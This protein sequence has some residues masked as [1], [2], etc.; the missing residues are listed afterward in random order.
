MTDRQIAQRFSVHATLEE[1]KLGTLL[2]TRDEERG[3][4]ALLLLLAATTQ[5]D[6]ATLQAIV[7]DQQPGPHLLATY[8]C[9]RTDEGAWLATDAS[10]LGAEATTLETVLKR[11]DRLDVQ[12]ILRLAVALARAADALGANGKRHLDISPNRVWLETGALTTGAPLLF[13]VGWW[14]LL[15][16]YQ[17]GASADEFYGN[18]EYLAAEVCKGHPASDTADVYGA[19]TTVWA[20][21]AGK[22]PFPSN[23]PLMA[24]K[25]QAVEKPLRLDLVK[26]AL[27]G[28][29]DLQAIL[30]EALD[31]DPAKRPAPT[32]W[33]TAVETLAS[34]KAPEVLQQ[35]KATLSPTPAIAAPPPP[36]STVP[37]KLPDDAA[38]L[39]ETMKFV[40]TDVAA[41]LAAAVASTES[42]APPS[43]AEDAAALASLPDRPAP[44]SDSAEP[45]EDDEGG[46]DG[47]DGTESASARQGRRRRERRERQTVAG[48]GIAAALAEANLADQKTGGSALA[49][50]TPNSLPTLLGVPRPTAGAAPAVP[51]SPPA[52]PAAVSP[53]SPVS[54]GGKRSEG[55]PPKRPD[56]QGSPRVIVNQPASSASNA[57]IA[58]TG[59]SLTVQLAEGAFFEDD[60]ISPSAVAD[61]GDQVPPTP[62]KEK[63]NRK[64]LLAI[65]TFAVLMV[66]V[67]VW[68]SQRSALPD[69]PAA[70]EPPAAAD[71]PA[72]EP[73][74][75]ATEAAAPVAVEVTPVVAAVAPTPTVAANPVPAAA[76]AQAV[77]AETLPPPVA[78]APADAG[79]TGDV[80]AAV[81]PMPTPPLVPV[82]AARQT[83][84]QRLVAEGNSALATKDP[85]T[86]LAKAQE[87]LKLNAGHAPALLLKEQAQRAVDAAIAESKAA[88][89]KV[90]AAK[91]Q[92]EATAE[93]EQKAVSKREAQK[94]AA[95][96]AQ[97]LK[98]ERAAA[99]K[100]AA[101]ARAKSAKERAIAKKSERVAA[102]KSADKEPAKKAEKEPAKKVEKEA[103]G[104]PVRPEARPVEKAVDDGNSATQEAS[105][106]AALAQKASKAKL[107]VL[108]LQK[109]IKLDPANAGYKAQLKS[110]EEQLKTEGP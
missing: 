60:A 54:P 31:K 107:K 6:D 42:S 65:G 102:T 94:A 26:P 30:A 14:R 88:E 2:W 98:A 72:I 34:Q 74:A 96:H 16:A 86:A 8:A 90:I 49:G 82:D 10:A 21:A 91:A 75:D 45:D 27:H 83:E 81:A 5:S 85:V 80:V 84:A 77:V 32:S 76:P 12:D 1:G 7:A 11:R 108:Y 63:L 58:R 51:P 13:G 24:L 66:G 69:T 68:M 61:L 105:K 62:P 41:A 29:K 19:A 43:A 64:A 15:P 104:R 79:R 110:A 103:V 59:R 4:P 23:Q 33:R 39:R 99:A 97:T 20:L 25:R 73:A 101:A 36:A 57:A 3:A 70:V 37:A 93:R 52:A 109:A 9:G 56:S 18:P 35:S 95:K 44:M 55:A 78:P 71:E 46:A 22:P 48:I 50:L 38:D 47:A 100:E 53:L 106:F 87:A 28:V 40:G 17:S 92:A 67:S 89:A